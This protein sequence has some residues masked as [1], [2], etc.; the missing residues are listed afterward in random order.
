ME[1][2]RERLQQFRQRLF[3]RVLYGAGHFAVNASALMK[4]WPD[5]KV[6]QGLI[7][8]TVTEKRLALSSLRDLIRGGCGAYYLSALRHVGIVLDK[9]SLMSGD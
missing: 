9:A 3:A 6:V 5:R 8:V 1:G 2:G 4:P 7:K